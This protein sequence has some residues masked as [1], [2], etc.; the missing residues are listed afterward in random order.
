MS[1]CKVRKKL[2]DQSGSMRVSGEKQC[3]QRNILAVTVSC[4]FVSGFAM[5]SMPAHATENYLTISGGGG[6]AGGHYNS[7]TA[8]NRG[9]GRVDDPAGN[10]GDSAS[11]GGGGGGGSFIGIPT[12]DPDGSQVRPV[13][14]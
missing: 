13:R 12:V 5:L 10:G 2:P 4:L 9:G 11:P 14:V 7:S 1:D 8:A 3:Q 6:G